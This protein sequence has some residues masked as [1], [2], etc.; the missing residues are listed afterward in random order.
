ME[1]LNTHFIEPS[2]Q[3]GDE[4]SSQ[5]RPWEDPAFWPYLTRCVTRVLV[6]FRR[7]SQSSCRTSLRGLSKASAFFLD[8][9]G[10]HPSTY[11]PPLAQQLSPLLTNHPRLH[12][13]AAERDFAIASRRWRDKVRTLRIELDRVP[14]HERDDGFENWWDRVSDI[15][16]ILEGR[17]DVVKKVCAELGADWKEVCA[18]YGV[19][20]DTR[21]RRQD[22]P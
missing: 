13:F 9:L 14:E 18:A 6:H 3:E 16:G 5:E 1:W 17:A 15:V 8:V 12:Q 11:L 4:L 21:L 19:F 7:R 2:T 22:L 20:V 10:K